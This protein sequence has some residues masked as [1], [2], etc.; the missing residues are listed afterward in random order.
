MFGADFIG[1][2]LADQPAEAVL[3]VPGYPIPCCP[4]GDAFLRGNLCELYV[5]FQERPDDPESLEGL[6]AFGS[7]RFVRALEV[8]S[9]G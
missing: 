7:V 2:R 1:P 5:I 6:P 3:A 9:S 4:H 8:V